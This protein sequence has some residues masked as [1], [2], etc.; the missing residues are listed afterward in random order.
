MKLNFDQIKDVT[1]GAVKVEFS[2]GEYRFFRF[3]EQELDFYKNT[4]H[5]AKVYSTAG[6]EMNFETDAS[7]VSLLG[8]TV[9]TGSTRGFYAIEVHS[10]DEIVG[11]IKNYDYEVT[12]ENLYDMLPLGE[13]SGRFELGSGTKR[14]RIVLP[15][16]VDTRICELE[17]CGASFLSPV[18]AQK[19]MLIY[20]DSITHGYDAQLPSRKYATVTARALG[21]QG[22]NK[23]VG[24]EVFQPSLAAI[25]NDF[26]PDYITVAYGTNDW[27][28]NDK[29]KFLADSRGF[30]ENLSKNYPDSKIFAIS[31]IWRA[32]TEKESDFSSFLDIEEQIKSISD[33]LDNVIFISGI[34]LVPH[35]PKYY[36]D[37]RLHPNDKGYE[38]YAR[39]LI[40]KIK[41]YI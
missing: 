37:L 35:D 26:T 30:Y 17:L 6:I 25:K 1:C 38:H 29:E 34:D 32:D 12:F 15:Q 4:R 39:N 14:V 16:F 5:A 11:I 27:S 13:F 36:S 41:E 22:Y 18:K 24:G 31:P 33:S 9:S 10:C 20:G 8:K 28:A 7:A 19:K 23:G 21:A 3:N 2:D 40:A